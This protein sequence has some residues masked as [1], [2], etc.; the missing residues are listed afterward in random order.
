MPSPTAPRCLLLRTCCSQIQRKISSIP[1]SLPINKTPSV[2]RSVLPSGTSYPSL[3]TALCTPFVQTAPS[4]RHP[5][6]K[7][8]LLRVW[9]LLWVFGGRWTVIWR[10]K[11]S[12]VSTLILP[13]SYPVTP[14]RRPCR[15]QIAD[16]AG[17]AG[18]ARACH[19]LLGN[20]LAT[21][22]ISSNFSCF[23]Q[24]HV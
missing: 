12:G 5:P 9:C 6:T 3:C 2:Q 16:R 10:T 14:K 8:P 4:A 21:F 7:F 1:I 24:T 17:H 19:K 23:E 22:R 11:Y 18:H 15:L 20:F 13:Y